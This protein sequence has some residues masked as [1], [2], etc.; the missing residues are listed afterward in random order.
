MWPLMNLNVRLLRKVSVVVSRAHVG[1]V[2]LTEM[3]EI[4][5]VGNNARKS[6]NRYVFAAM[7]AND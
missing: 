5:A 1:Y 7:S 6:P 4:R 2:G 3:C